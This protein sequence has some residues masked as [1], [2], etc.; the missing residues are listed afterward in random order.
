MVVGGGASG[1]LATL[2]LRLYARAR[3]VP[4]HLVLI[5][6]DR[7]H[8]LGQAYATTDPHHLL[9]SRAEKMS[10]L[11]HDSLHFVRWLH[12]QGLNAAGPD[13]L[14]RHVYGRYL[15]EL[16]EDASPARLTG[17]VVALTCQPLR[18]HLSDREALDADAVI[19]ATGNPA[20][21]TPI[22]V[23]SERY[24]ADPW[25]DGA[26]ARADHG[27]VLIMGTGLTMVDVAVTLSRTA[28]RT[29]YAISRHGLL[30]Q[31]HCQ[32]T[33][34]CA[35][36]P[37]PDGPLR[38]RGLLSAVRLAIRHS[39]G[40]WRGVLDSLRPRVPELW[41]RL[42]ADEQRRFLTLLARYWE[43]HRHRIPPETA[44]RLDDLRTAGRLRVLRGHVAEATPDSAGLNLRLS[45]D[46]GT[47]D[48]QVAWLVNTTGPAFTVPG[49]GV[50]SR[51]LADGLARPDPLG[52]GLDADA[53]GRVLDAA[54]R[55]HE[56]IVTLGPTLRGKLYETTAI[57]E[58]R[59]QA[60]NLAAY[61]IESITR[62]H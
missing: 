62:G 11:E 26:L 58:I 10:A 52:L 23:P 47:R 60:A 41:E 31:P 46:G 19:L 61:L 57:P 12:A 7:R 21:A 49:E 25:A 8:G 51:L 56:R 34:P 24:I 42:P 40:D 29:V 17:D 36:V 15:R 5:D 33:P 18:V 2:H 44:S 55:P 50:L 59:A 35:P 20:S 43:V 27:D 54:G 14:P 16:L 9:N 53:C 13:F 1:T 30:P 22:P 39:G 48:L 37:I 6:R 28:A 45:V 3:G 32:P 38:L 4:L